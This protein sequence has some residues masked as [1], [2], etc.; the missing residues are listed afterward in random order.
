MASDQR[1]CAK[2]KIYWDR[3]NGLECPKCE[4]HAF[5]TFNAGDIGTAIY[6]E[7]SDDSLKDYQKWECSP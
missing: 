5:F 1:L 4:A 2:C 6:F 7:H 3:E